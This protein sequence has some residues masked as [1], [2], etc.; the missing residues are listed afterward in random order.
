[1]QIGAVAGAVEGVYAVDW[2]G[3]VTWTRE[4]VCAIEGDAS[5]PGYRVSTYDRSQG[6]LA[7]TIDVQAFDGPGDYD[8]DEF[9]PRPVVGVD[10]TD[11][12]DG[13]RWHLGTDSGGRCSITVEEPSLSGF[14]SCVDVGVFM[15]GVPTED[16]ASVDAVWSCAQVQR[17][18]RV[19][20][21]RTR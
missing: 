16:L 21:K 9:Q 14:V 7:V 4:V 12:S 18:G 5:E 2:D 3:G 6:E 11:E 15:D 20:A 10:W 8:R 19:T 1:M 13:T 17:G